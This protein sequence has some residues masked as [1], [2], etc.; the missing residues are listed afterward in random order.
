MYEKGAYAHCAG[1]PWR[2]AN[3]TELM[4]FLDGPCQNCINNR[5]PLDMCEAL[6]TIHTSKETK[7]YHDYDGYPQCPDRKTE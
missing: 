6:E 7:F 5:G 4:F 3:H 2:P 1:Q